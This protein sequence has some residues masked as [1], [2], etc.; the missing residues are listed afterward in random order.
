MA[1]N[2]N[3]ADSAHYPSMRSRSSC[4]ND[5]CKKYGR[6]YTWSA[7]MDSVGTFSTNGKGCG[8]G[9]TCSVTYPVRGICPNGWHVPSNEELWTLR[10]TISQSTGGKKLKSAFGWGGCSNSNDRHEMDEY[11]FTALPN[12]FRYDSEDRYYD[13]YAFFYSSTEISSAL[14]YFLELTRCGDGMGVNT[15]Y[16]RNRPKVKQSQFSLRCLKD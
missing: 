10:S 11:G 16:G 13:G 6:L 15:D 2:L 1:E 3:Y 4:Y 9:T 7:V 8:A 12:G 5:S 14:V